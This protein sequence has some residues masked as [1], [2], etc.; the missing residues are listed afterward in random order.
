M[1]GGGLLKSRNWVG[2]MGAL[3]V[4]GVAA[5]TVPMALVV[6]NPTSAGPGRLPE[7]WQLKVHRG[8]PDLA[9]I[10]EGNSRVL[11]FKSHKSSFGIERGVDVDVNQY[12]LLTWNWK[13]S[14]LPAG[15]DFRRYS[16]DD[17]A[18]Q[19][20]VAFD[21]HRILSYI[22]DSSAPKGDWQSASSF[23]LLHIFA[24]VCHSGAA[25]LNQWLAET[26]NVAADFQKAYQRGPSRVKGIR[27]QINSQHTGSSAESYFG[28]V[29]FRAA[30]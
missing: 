9:V 25:E 28:D 19:V 23:P 5:A 22:W 14:A 10:G 8:S 11:R 16:T 21:D 1:G 6:L 4:I 20:L 30:Q 7:G 26:H 24:L 15:G 29:S 18:A 12:P 2:I 27:L 17:Q 13:V 3:A